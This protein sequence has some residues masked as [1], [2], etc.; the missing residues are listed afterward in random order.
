MKIL[1]TGGAGYLGSVLSLALVEKGHEIRLLD[2]LMYGGRSL[3][4]MFG[5]PR[6]EAMIGDVR[7]SNTVE[8]AVAGVDAVVHLAAI[9]GDPACARDPEA[10]RAIN[11][12]ASL[13]LVRAARAGG[14]SRFIFASTCSN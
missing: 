12:Y 9:V 14:V 5:H 3:L 10:A 6:F 13:E 7:D 1:I 11:E 2:N 4:S 8:R